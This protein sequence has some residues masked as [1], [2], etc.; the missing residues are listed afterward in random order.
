MAYAG[1]MDRRAQAAGAF[2][3]NTLANAV[4][5]PEGRVVLAQTGIR[6]DTVGFAVYYSRAF[7]GVTRCNVFKAEENA[8]LEQAEFFLR[9]DAPS[10]VEIAV[11]EGGPE[12]NSPYT[13]V[14]SRNLGMIPETFGFVSSGALELP[15][16]AGRHYAVGASWQN[17]ARIYRES[18]GGVSFGSFQG[19]IGLDNAYPAPATLTGPDTALPYYMRLRTRSG[20]AHAAAGT[21]VSPVIAPSSLETWGALT[22]GV[23]TPPGTALAVD[24]L[25]E[26]GENPVPGFAGLADGASLAALP[27]QPVRL[28]ARLSTTNAAATPALSHWGVSWKAEPGGII[29]GPWSNTVHSIQDGTPPRVTQITLLDP[30][31]TRAAQV[32]FRV[33]FNKPVFGVG[34]APPFADLL[35]RGE[36]PGAAVLAVE[37]GDS[38]CDVTVATGGV[39][40]A[41]GLDVLATGGIRDH[42]DRP[43]AADYTGGPDYALDFIPPRVTEIV[44]LDPSPTNAP[45]VR[46]RVQFSESV[47]GVPAAPPFAGFAVEGLTGAAV[48]S[49]LHGGS[50]CVV[51]AATGGRDG[52]LRLRVRAAECPLADAAG[53]PLAEDAL[54]A[55][56]YQMAHLRWTQTPA[57]EIRAKTGDFL[58]LVSAAAGGVEPK[59]WQW[60]HNAGGKAFLPVQGGVF[61]ALTL[62]YVSTRDAGDYYCEVGDT[63]ETIHTPVTRLLVE[64]TLDAPGGLWLAVLAL[65]AAAAG[66]WRL[67]RTKRSAEERIF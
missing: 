45:V 54:S 41:L 35:P 4:T 25:P 56:P 11:Y 66:A 32:R 6:T 53:W 58:R 34:D 21:C 59:R 49:L 36:I 2:A 1:G 47:T 15:L 38:F 51:S 64:N 63:H 40:G 52:A 3:E 16:V 60:F 7:T 28:R 37:A 29:A 62:S 43:M 22:C 26:T 55:P 50:S 23:E 61:P 65:L 14:F 19:I 8:V 18:A 39:S 24:I 30:S 44:P 27:R 12:F 9:L 10:P 17:S 48:I 57:G 20:T 42:L 46:W 5:D 13:L 67:R 33:A 31:P